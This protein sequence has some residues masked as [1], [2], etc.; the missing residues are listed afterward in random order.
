MTFVDSFIA[1]KEALD[2]ITGGWPECGFDPRPAEQV[3]SFPARYLWWDEHDYEVEGGDIKWIQPLNTR[4]MVYLDLYVQKGSADHLSLALAEAVQT[5][6]DKIRQLTA[7]PI[8]FR[9]AVS[10]VDPI[11]GENAPWAAA[12]LTILVGTFD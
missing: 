7:T 2:E 11:Y 10:H 1:I 5:H 6:V 9:C 8:G 12:R 4:A 3:G